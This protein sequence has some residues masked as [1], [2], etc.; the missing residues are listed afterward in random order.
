M[1]AKDTFLIILG[2]VIILGS[3]YFMYTQSSTTV[4]APSSEAQINTDL[5]VE[6][7][8]ITDDT[9]PFKIDITYP[10]IA[11]LDE[12]NK[13]IQDTI[14]KQISEFKQYSLE[15]DEA[16]KKIDPE[17]YA[18][19]PREYDL[20]IGYE[21]GQ[22]NENVASV[23]LNVY[24]FVGGAHGSQ[25]FTPFNYDI[26]NKKFLKI[27]DMFAGQDAMQKISEYCAKDLEIQIGK[28]MADY[29]TPTDTEW[30][31]RGTEA[32]EDNYSRFLITDENIIIYFP[33]YQV[34]AYALGSFKV[35][36]PKNI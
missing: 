20:T 25:S 8:K 36:V 12:L 4:K 27:S 26:K 28:I 2:I 3:A 11:G 5:K 15:N 34:A 14:D 23:M 33:Q 1:K 9:K 16:I 21:K 31:K 30:I 19:Y 32:K 10:Y 22:V 35:T 7:K 13:N 17:S 24:S 6:D 29:G 18:K